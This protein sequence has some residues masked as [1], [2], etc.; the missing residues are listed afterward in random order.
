MD[1]RSNGLNELALHHFKFLHDR[2]NKDS[3][4]LHNLALLYADC[5]LPISSVERYKKA[6]LMGETLSAANLGFMYL[7]GG[8]EQEARD[9]AEQAMKIENHTTKVEECLAEI[10]QRGEK[11]REKESAILEVANANR[12]LFVSMGQALTAAA[13]PFAGIW[14]FPFGYIPMTVDSNQVSG[15]VDI[16][17]EETGLGAL[18]GT[19][20]SRMVRIDR[21][22]LHGKLTGAVC[23]FNLTVA[24]VGPNASLLGTSLHPRYGTRSG[25]ISYAPDGRSAT[26]VELSGQK[27]GKPEKLTKV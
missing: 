24:D 5:K 12:N 14:K 15:S 6:L 23:E 4:A 9:L 13:P 26:Y 27:L 7:D 20:S 19:P 25:F 1:Y 10:I 21:Y 17:T 2:N 11:E 3:G 16:K 22:M 18:F 8:M